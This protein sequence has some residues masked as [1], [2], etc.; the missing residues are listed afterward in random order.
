MFLNNFNYETK[1]SNY[2][3]CILVAKENIEALFNS[4]SKDYHCI[5]FFTTE[6]SLELDKLNIK[7]EHLVYLDKEGKAKLS[8]EFI[9]FI[10]SDRNNFCDDMIKFSYDDVKMHRDLL[11]AYLDYKK[12][13]ALLY[14]NLYFIKPFDCSYGP[15]VNVESESHR[16]SISSNFGFNAV[17]AKTVFK[18]D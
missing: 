4:K 5:D 11:K 15:T 8:D 14:N 1:Q 3:N 12:M 16:I 13:N 17:E 7:L 10:N 18:C 9:N 2:S 6:K